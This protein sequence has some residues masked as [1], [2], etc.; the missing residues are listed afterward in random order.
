MANNSRIVGAGLTVIRSYFLPHLPRLERL[1]L[2]NR[3]VIY[4]MRKTL[5][6]KQ[7]EYRINALANSINSPLIERD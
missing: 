2:A 3:R 7:L 5:W 6:T 4:Q 1:L